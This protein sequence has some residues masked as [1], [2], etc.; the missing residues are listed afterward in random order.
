MKNQTQSNDKHA[1]GV[2]EWAKHSVNIQDGCEHDCRYCYAK[3]M[4]IRFK[5]ATAASWGKPRLR[6]HD[7]DR[8]FTKRAGRIMF[9]TAHDITARNHINIS[10]EIRSVF[11][12]RWSS[13]Y[14][15]GHNQ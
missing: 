9:P 1:H 10:G 14:V 3:T 4:A 15:V 12:R 7:V 8:G 11:F 6:Q 13:G 5:R 2:G